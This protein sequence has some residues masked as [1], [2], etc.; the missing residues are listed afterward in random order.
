MQVTIVPASAPGQ[1]MQLFTTYVVN[2]TVA[3]DAGSLG[4]V[5]SLAEMSRIRHVLI[6]HSH[7]DHI[8]ALGPFLDAV[9][10]GSGD[11]VVVHGNAHAL[12]CLK[13][14]IFNNRVYPDFLKIST[15]RP[16][17]L[18]FNELKSGQ[19]VDLGGLRV[20]P[21]EV[22]HVVPTLGYV[23]EDDQ[24]AVVFPSDTAPT[25]EIWKV[26]NHCPHLRAVFLECTFPGS[27]TWLAEIA[28]H[29]TPALYAQEM[30]KVN[31]PVRYITVHTH[32]RHR[33][34]VV[35]E[36]LAMNL[37]GVEIGEAGKP[38]TI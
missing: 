18:K 16:P 24:A 33:P 20:T 34:L 21:V 25:E 29:L 28:K 22:N 27:M 2:G 31:R 13:T 15:F 23:L 4:M 10:D 7:L 1:A 17:Y 37:P 3:V 9:Y 32:P 5:G 35:Q 14:D 12:E 8:A 36:L 30:K 38:Y 6:T 19:A 11:C 26:A